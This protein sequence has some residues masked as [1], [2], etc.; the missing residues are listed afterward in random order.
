VA[1]DDYATS[2]IHAH[3][4]SLA[5]L[6][7]M[8][9]PGQDWRA[10]DI[11]TGAG[12]TALTMA[13]HVHSVMAT[14]LTEA[15]LDK[16]AELALEQGL[17]NVTTRRADA[18]SLP[19]DDGCCDLVTCRLAFHHFA[20]PEQALREMARVLRPG[21]VLGLS[22][23]ITV[24]DKA[25]ADYYNEYERLRDPSHYR[26]W[27]K[28]ELI[29]M[30]TAAGF[31][32]TEPREFTKEFEFQVWA[33]RQRVSAADKRRLLDMMRAIPAALQPLFDP[34]WEDGTMYFHLREI[35]ILAKQD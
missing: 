20:R 27:S 13:P 6:L 8:I 24:D 25:A 5:A 26:V 12:H 35:V 11:A 18:E 30:I 1:A 23:N 32:L 4:E 7:D 21:G 33:D 14:D 29:E 17:A 2:D 28:S 19:L 9:E 3:G 22:D 10:V 16:V 15:M 34:R 31:N